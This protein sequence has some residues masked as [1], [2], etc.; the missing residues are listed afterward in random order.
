M[1]SVVLATA[2]GLAVANLYYAQ[3]LLDL[4]A[5]S[6]GVSQGSAAMVVT[7]T[8]IGYAAGLI[9]LLPLGDRLENRSL[10]ARTLIGTG[11]ALAVAA[12]APGF[13][14]FLA[15]SV[16]IGVTSVVAQVLVP[17]AAHLAPEDQRGRFV[18]RV[19][20]GLLLGILLARTL[21]SLV[22]AAWGWRTVFVVSAVLMLVTSIVL[23]RLLPER[24]PEFAPTY[25]QSLASLGDL[26]GAEPLLRRRALN[27]GLLFG[28]FSAFWTAI[29][30]EL[31]GEHHL[32]QAGIGVF[33]LVGAAG[34]A[35][36][37]V[38]GWIGDRGW[39]RAGTT[40]SLVVSVA[41]MVLAAAGRHS[42]VLLAVSAVLL[43]LAVQTHLV[44]SQRV[45]FALRPAARA[46]VNSVFMG[47]V[48][49]G[50][51]I[52]SAVAGQLHDLGGWTAAAIFGAC[53]A[54]VALALSVLRDSS[55]DSRAVPLAATVPTIRS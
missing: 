18:G 19:M 30:Y 46:R 16:L 44:L 38:A 27:Q 17:L 22:A 33:A 45:I 31:V 7:L 50:G 13:P 6:F 25:R 32:S 20:S 35:A 34:A 47:T 36:A 54:V 5:R 42:V 1:L 51:A 15:M 14:L 43:D 2:C 12:V 3:P 49:V 24:R 53:L 29:T 48:F 52:A 4:L 9:F 8:Q 40:A 41:A 39:G 26:V 21:S 10:A 28:A 11:I 55:D 37:P 23:R